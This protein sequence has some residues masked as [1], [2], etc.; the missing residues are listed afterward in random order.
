MWG[1]SY[2]FIIVLM[3]EE[4][5]LNGVVFQGK[6]T[7]KEEK[8]KKTTRSCIRRGSRDEQEK[9]PNHDLKQRPLG[10]WGVG[11]DSVA[12]EEWRPAF[13]H[14]P[15]GPLTTVSKAGKMWVPAPT[16]FHLQVIYLVERVIQRS[17]VSLSVK[18][19]QPL[20]ESLP[21]RPHK[22]LTSLVM[23]PT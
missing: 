3:G 4:P 23:S 17:L 19:S 20:G 14:F 5:R 18:R 11:H 13:L 22:M 9:D 6:K 12:N 15:N 10:D 21:E 1:N 7:S 16:L 8:E 2:Y